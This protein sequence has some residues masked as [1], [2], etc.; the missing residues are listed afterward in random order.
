MVSNRSET[1]FARV[2]ELQLED[3]IGELKTRGFTTYAKFA[4]GCEYNPQMADASI[5]TTQ[6]LKPVAKNDDDK[7]PGLRMLW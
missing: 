1:F 2:V 6:L 5:L 7:I 3:C 4:Y